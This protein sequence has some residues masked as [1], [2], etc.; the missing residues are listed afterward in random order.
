MKLGL[1]GDGS[2]VVSMLAFYSQNPCLNP[3]E[4]YTV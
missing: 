3:T 2:L 1:G 4:V